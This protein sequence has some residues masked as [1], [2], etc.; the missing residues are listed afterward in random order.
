ME[1]Y[2]EMAY[3]GGFVC[4][5]FEI[6]NTPRFGKRF[7]LIKWWNGEVGLVYLKWYLFNLNGDNGIILIIC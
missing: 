3:F 1:G 7:H 2:V 4:W 5:G 6:V